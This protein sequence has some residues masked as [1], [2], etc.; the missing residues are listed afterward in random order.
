MLA[1]ALILR[2]RLILHFISVYIEMKITP[3]LMI[4]KR[5]LNKF[6]KHAIEL[7]IV[8]ITQNSHAL[9]TTIEKSCLD[10]LKS[11]IKMFCFIKY[12]DYFCFTILRFT[13]LQLYQYA[14]GHIDVAVFLL[15]LPGKCYPAIHI[16][17][18]R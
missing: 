5:S 10:I 2:I 16:S 3:F 9:L 14:T 17:T 13:I 11:R 8:W 7:H 18:R 15:Y 12:K 1:F 4:P 6:Q